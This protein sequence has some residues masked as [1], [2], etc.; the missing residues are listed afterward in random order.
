VRV[1]GLTGRARA[2]KDT[3]AAMI[4]E[5][6]GD[7]VRREALADRLK[8]SAAR[9]L[10]F[11]GS[12]EELVGVMDTLKVCGSV[13]AAVEHGQYDVQESF[14]NGR[15]FLQRYGTEAHRDVFGVDFW[16][17]AVLPL[18]DEGNPSRNDHDVLI[19]SDVRFP[20]EAQRVLDYGGEVWEVIR[21]EGERPGAE[22]VS[23]A[24]VPPSLVT[25]SIVNGGTLDELRA[26]VQWA[27]S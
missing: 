13:H 24:G 9:A 21:P 5:E 17:D 7:F 25:L 26:S 6:L 3:V 18:T 11:D 23:E 15:E 12:D 10:G 19:V 8:V 22:H 27:L 20:N 14:L 16:L 2:G 1:I 4:A